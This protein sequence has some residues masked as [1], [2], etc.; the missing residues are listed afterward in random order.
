MTVHLH[1]ERLVLDGL[2]AG[3]TD[4]ELIAAELRAELARSLAARPLTGAGAVGGAL[5]SGRAS[6]IRLGDGKPG[7]IG[8]R[9]AASVD[10]AVRAASGGA[11]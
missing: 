10:G 1:V 7:T 3:S 2:G 6:A 11:R 4:A 5:H 8:R 9:V